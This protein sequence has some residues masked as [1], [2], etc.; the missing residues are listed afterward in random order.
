MND[1]LELVVT[2]VVAVA[3]FTALYKI[4]PFKKYRVTKPKFALFPKYIAVFDGPIGDIEKSLE[5]LEFKK[6]NTNI[7]SRG[8]IYGDFSAKAIKLSV[9]ID[10]KESLIKV[11]ASFFGILFDTGDIWQVTTDILNG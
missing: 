6:T 11:Y 8:K 5:S 2:V 3:G 10:E 7:Y 4:L 1:V 9:K